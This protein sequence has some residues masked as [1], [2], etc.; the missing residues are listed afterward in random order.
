[1]ITATRSSRPAPNKPGATEYDFHSAL[2][3]GLGAPGIGTKIDFDIAGEVRT[4]MTVCR[5]RHPCS[6][7]RR[8][9]G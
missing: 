9:P 6:T 2:G 3:D 7:R 8:R 1:M 4:G 5:K